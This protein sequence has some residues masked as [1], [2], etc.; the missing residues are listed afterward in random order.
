MIG[1]LAGINEAANYN[2]NVLILQGRQGA[3]KTRWVRN[4]IES[5]LEHAQLQSNRYFVEKALDSK[6]KDD[7]KL[8]CQ[9]FVIFYDEMSGIVNNKSDIEAFKNLTSSKSQT[10]RKAYGRNE[11]EYIR[12]ASIIGT[13][14]DKHFLRDT[15]GNR[16]FWIIA[17]GE[18]ESLD[19][20]ELVMVWAQIKHLYLE[21]EKHYMNSQERAQLDEY[22]KEFEAKS[23]EEEMIIGFVHPCKDKWMTATEILRTIESIENYKFNCSLPYFGKLLQ[24]HFSKLSKHSNRGTVYEVHICY[25]GQPIIEGKLSPEAL[26]FLSIKTSLLQNFTY[27]GAAQVG[28]IVPVEVFVQNSL[29]KTE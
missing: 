29:Q 27:G 10:L 18:I 6:N 24:K 4:L 2:E 21:K 12:T 22:L 28:S 16:R 8:L 13:V 9:S 3:G 19:S 15:T 1:V 5:L 23:I 11:N 17:C 20:N 14:N 25:K 7:M 26:E